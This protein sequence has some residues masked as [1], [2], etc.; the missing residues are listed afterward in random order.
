MLQLH[1]RLREQKMLREDRSPTNSPLFKQPRPKDRYSPVE[2]DTGV[3]E[4]FTVTELQQARL[5]FTAV[6]SQKNYP[7]PRPRKPPAVVAK[8]TGRNSPE[9]N[10]PQQN[11]GK[12][13]RK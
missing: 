4:N 2:L 5:N 12:H 13:K 9:Q 7:S 6:N 11:P 1:E 10:F 8:P 3:K